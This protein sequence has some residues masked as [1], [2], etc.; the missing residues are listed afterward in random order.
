MAPEERSVRQSRQ[1]WH[2]LARTKVA[3][4]TGQAGGLSEGRGRVR[5]D[6]GAGDQ[7][8]RGVTGVQGRADG[9]R[10]VVAGDGDDRPVRETRQRFK[11]CVEAFDDTALRSGILEVSCLVR[12]LD[13][14]VDEV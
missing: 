4:V 5:S 9:R 3:Q 8:R 11:T 12:R 7:Q 2:D 1:K 14:D 10:G 13:V 6:A